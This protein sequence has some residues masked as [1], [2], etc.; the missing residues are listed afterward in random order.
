MTREKEYRY[1]CPI[2]DV[3]DAGEDGKRRLGGYAAVFDSI[4]PIGGEYREVIRPGAFTKTLRESDVVALWNHETGTVLGRMGN[5]TLTL[6]ED[7]H[8]LRFNLDLPDTT[9]GRDAFTLARRGDVANMSFGFKPIRQEWSDIDTG[10]PLRELREVAL[11]EVSPVT[12]PAY[13]ATSVEARSVLER[14]KKS[15]DQ[16]DDTTSAPGA[17]DSVHPEAGPSILILRRRLELMEVS[18]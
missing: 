2:T 12:F 9:A 11:F 8:G 10:D 3:R 7:D 18:L 14:A 16:G 17:E 5:G 4:E 1:T 15:G 13:K 6:A